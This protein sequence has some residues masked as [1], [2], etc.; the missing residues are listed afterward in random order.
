MPAADHFV[1]KEPHAEECGENQNIAWDA[2][3]GAPVEGV[4]NF[5]QQ[6]AEGGDNS[7]LPALQHAADHQHGKQIQEAEGDVLVSSP[8][9]K[10]D[11]GD[12]DSRPQQD[13]LSPAAKKEG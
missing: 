12:E 2:G 13:G 6:G 5:S 4:E 8:V 3:A 7:D 1:D 11:D 10:R 9:G